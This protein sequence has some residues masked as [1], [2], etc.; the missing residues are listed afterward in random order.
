MISAYYVHGRNFK[1]TF[2]FVQIFRVT[3]GLYLWINYF[4]C[5][6]L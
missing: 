6:I 2:D 1:W 3:N 4:I 5:E